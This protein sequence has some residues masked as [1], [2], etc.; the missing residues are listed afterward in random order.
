MRRNRYEYLSEA[1]L[2]IGMGSTTS[3]ALPQNT[4]RQNRWEKRVQTT[5]MGNVHA[6]AFSFLLLFPL[7]N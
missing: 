6:I 5:P 7:P 4:Q 2:P 1:Q 3:K